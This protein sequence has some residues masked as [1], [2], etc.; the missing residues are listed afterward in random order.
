MNN[1]STK[2]KELSTYRIDNQLVQWIFQMKSIDRFL[3]NIQ[4]KILKKFQLKNVQIVY[5]YVACNFYV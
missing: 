3:K 5:T 2:N 1:F 4:L